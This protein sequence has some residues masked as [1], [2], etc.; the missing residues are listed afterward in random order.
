MKIQAS[1]I[2]IRMLKE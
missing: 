1:L 2:F